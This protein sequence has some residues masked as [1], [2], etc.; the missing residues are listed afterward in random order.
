MNKVTVEVNLSF[1]QSVEAVWLLAV[2]IYAREFSETSWLFA[3]S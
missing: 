1:D 2:C 3:Y